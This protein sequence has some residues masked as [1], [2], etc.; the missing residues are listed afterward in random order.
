M[1]EWSGIAV[2]P[3]PEQAERFPTI[4]GLTVAESALTSPE[5]V[6]LKI[7]MQDFRSRASNQPCYLKINGPGH[8]E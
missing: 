2:E 3:L 4:P 5:N 8:R 7:S 1:G 6:S